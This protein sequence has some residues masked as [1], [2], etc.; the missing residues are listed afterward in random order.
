MKVKRLSEIMVI[1]LRQQR[2]NL[3]L[4]FFSF[5]QKL[6]KRPKSVINGYFL[7]YPEFGGYLNKTGRPIVYSCSWPAYDG[8]VRR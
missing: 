3:Q 6:C 7:G 5:L 4:I 1:L 2:P 8:Q